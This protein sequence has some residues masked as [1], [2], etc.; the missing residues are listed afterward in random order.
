MTP[1]KR[2][3]R[4]QSPPRAKSP[5]EI[6]AGVFVGGWKDAVAFDGARFCVLDEA[7][8][9]MPEATH[10]PIYDESTDRA[11]PA[12]LDRL[13]SAIEKAH[14]GGRPVL[15]FCGHGIRRSP[16]GGAW[17]LHRTEGVSLEEAY[18]RIR[19]VRPKVERASSWVGN[20]DELEA[21]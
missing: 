15:V 8:P 4:N 16:L 17:Y 14:A 20:A 9:D 5:S 11:N 10:I 2:S 3:P 13:A 19:S 7:P 1:E 18:E 12:N 6:A 21:A